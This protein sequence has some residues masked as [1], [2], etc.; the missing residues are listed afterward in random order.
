MT[1]QHAIA[2]RIHFDARLLAQLNAHN[3]GLIHFDFGGDDR[4][5]SDRHQGRPRLVLNPNDGDLPFVYRQVRDDAVERRT[6]RRLR[7]HISGANQP[8]TL[9]RDSNSGAVVLLQYL[10]QLR[11]SLREACPRGI[12]LRDA[13]VV[14]G[15]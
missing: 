1:Q 9:L 2:Q 13:D 7:K 8:R 4:H 12:Q 10:A 15:A 3:I 5:V 6:Y 14:V 11:F